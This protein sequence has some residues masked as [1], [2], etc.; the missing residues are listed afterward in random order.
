M[1]RL[2]LLLLQAVLNN[3]NCTRIRMLQEG[4]CIHT[5]KPVRVAPSVVQKGG[6][7]E[8]RSVS[9]ALH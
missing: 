4:V 1:L 3:C 5:I 7:K 6:K 2:R 9:V 8:G